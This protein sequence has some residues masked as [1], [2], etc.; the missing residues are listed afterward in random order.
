[1]TIVDENG[2][3]KQSSEP[4]YIHEIVEDFREKKLF[5]VPDFVKVKGHTV[6]ITTKGR[7]EFVYGIEHHVTT[8]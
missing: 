3:L 5:P 1:M 4:K 6:R 2:K 7:C 8:E